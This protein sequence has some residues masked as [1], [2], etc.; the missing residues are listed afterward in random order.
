M[1]SGLSVIPLA[2]GG[3]GVGEFDKIDLLEKRLLTLVFGYSKLP[4]S[5]Y[6]IKSKT[7]INAY[8]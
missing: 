1:L 2:R 7:E 5:E 6:T 3:D 4:Q 8:G